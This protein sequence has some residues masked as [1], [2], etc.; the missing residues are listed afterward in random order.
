MGKLKQERGIYGRRE[1]TDRRNEAGGKTE[2]G[3]GCS[4]RHCSST[5]HQINFR[6]GAAG[7]VNGMKIR[8]ATGWGWY[9]GRRK[10]VG[11]EAQQQ[12]HLQAHPKKCNSIIRMLGERKGSPSNGS[13]GVARA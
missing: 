10:G 12:H 6:T 5:Q 13:R 2:T 11:M 1:R 7:C 3:R 9:T 4:E 8:W